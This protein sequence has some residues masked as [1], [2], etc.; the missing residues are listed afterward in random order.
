MLPAQG[1]LLPENSQDSAPIRVFLPQAFSGRYSEF[2]PIVSEIPTESSARTLINL[3][4]SESSLRTG[5]SASS[6]AFELD[7][8]V[9]SVHSVILVD[10]LYLSEIPCSDGAKAVPF[11]QDSSLVPNWSCDI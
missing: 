4:G 10:T 8:I 6:T 11:V 9:D 7:M 3:P 2:G 5:W 1:W